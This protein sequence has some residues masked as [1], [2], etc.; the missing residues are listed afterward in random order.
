MRPYCVYADRSQQLKKENKHQT[1]KRKKRRNPNIKEKTPDVEIHII[2][3][4]SCLF[5]PTLAEGKTTSKLLSDEKSFHYLHF[6]FTEK[7]I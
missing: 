2:H 1:Q 5:L 3:K 4:Q 6:T 7:T